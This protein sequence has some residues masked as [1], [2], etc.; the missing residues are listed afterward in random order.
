[1]ELKTIREVEDLKGKR[2]LL[3]LDLNLPVVGKEVINDYRLSKSLATIEFLQKAEAKIVIISHIWEEGPLSL[4]PVYE[5]LK[6][7]FKIDAQFMDSCIGL[8]V[9]DKTK[10]IGDGEILML[11]NLR[12]HKG[13]MENSKEFTEELSRLGDIYVNDAFAVMH[14]DHASITTLPKYLPTY[15][16]FLVEEEFKYLSKV[17]EPKRPFLFILGGAKFDTKMPIIKKYLN[18]ADYVFAGGALANDFFRAKGFDIADSLVS[19]KDYGTLEMLQNE[20]LLLPKD[21]TVKNPDGVFVKSPSEVTDGDRIYDLGPA[22]MVELKDIIFKSKFILW[23]GPIGDYKKGFRDGTLDLANAITDSGAE[24]IVGGG[25]TFAVISKLGLEDRF[26][27]MSTAG[28]AML[29][30]ISS[31]SLIGLEPVLRSI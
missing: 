7:K 21:V 12:M 10:T 16:G 15:A 26:T 24:S 13:E 14:R 22:A 2:V 17:K 23:N 11:E 27:F 18:I 3:R 8:D 5:L 29:E 20:K 9:V 25:D 31:G 4:K 6:N 19:G 30:F 28:G 1:M